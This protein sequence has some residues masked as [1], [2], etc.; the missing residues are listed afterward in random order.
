MEVEEPDDEIIWM[1]INAKLPQ[2]KSSFKIL[3]IAA[4]IL[5]LVSITIVITWMVR[6]PRQ[7]TVS[8]ASLSPELANEENSF[9]LVIDQKLKE[10]K[11]NNI[12][13]EDYAPFFEELEMLDKLNHEALKD[14]NTGPVNPRLI[15]MLLK[16]YEQ[17][18][19]ILEQ[20]LNEIEKNKYH[21][22]KII[23]I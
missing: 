21:E 19:R 4:A 17:K 9:M 20:L 1:G 8:L 5:I 18:I 13:K 2:K 3:K 15:S 14:L 16:Y 12:K 23:E 6:P 7:S 10:I 22:S 11:E